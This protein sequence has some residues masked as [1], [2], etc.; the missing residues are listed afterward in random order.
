V[1]YLRQLLVHLALIF[2]EAI[3]DAAGGAGVE[4]RKRRT[5]HLQNG[6]GHVGGVKQPHRRH[7]DKLTW[8]ATRGCHAA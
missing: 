4:E 5:Q 8:P 2:A 6:S 7:K 3:E 1:P